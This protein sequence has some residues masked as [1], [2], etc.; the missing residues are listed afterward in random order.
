MKLRCLFMLEFG[1]SHELW[2]VDLSLL[3]FLRKLN[4]DC[5]SLLSSKRVI[6]QLLSPLSEQWN[7]VKKFSSY[8]FRDAYN[9]NNIPSI[10]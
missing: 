9:N 3:S 2:F 8:T 10:L 7:D 4:I 1:T 6:N 5:L